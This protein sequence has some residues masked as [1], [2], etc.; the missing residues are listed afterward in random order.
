MV[1]VN[2]DWLCEPATALAGGSYIATATQTDRNGLTSAQSLPA[3]FTVE[4]ADPGHGLGRRRRRRSH[5]RRRRRRSH[6]RG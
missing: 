3:R 5:G 1:D 4:L 6:G 2:R